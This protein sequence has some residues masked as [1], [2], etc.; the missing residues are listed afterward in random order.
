[1]LFGLILFVFLAC[2]DTKKASV[3]KES[4]PNI[5]SSSITEKKDSISTTINTEEK[6]TYTKITQ[7]NC[8]SFLTEY[9]VN[10]PET[11]VRISTLHG[12]IDIQLFKDTPLHRANFIYMVKQKYFNNTYFHRIVPNFII[13]GGNSDNK[14]TSKKRRIIGRNYFLPS[15]ITT[16]RIHKYGTISGAKEY[17]DN[18]DKMSAPFEF[19]IFLGPLKHTGHLNGDYTIFGE[20]T[21]GMDVV[22]TIANLP[23]DNGDW[24]LVNVY[25]TA[26]ILE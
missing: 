21:K 19:F 25:I 11:K 18:P 9:G 6:K 17:R 23:A 20:V 1:M 12:D 15:E 13:Q 4:I 22:E 10:N 26:E 24:P 7:E 5:D 3:R 8:V 14:S 2:E 16:K